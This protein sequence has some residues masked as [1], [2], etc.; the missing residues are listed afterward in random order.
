M[1]SHW[2]SAEGWFLGYNAPLSLALSECY[3]YQGQ[4]VLALRQETQSVDRATTSQSC[5]YNSCSLL[6]VIWLF[7]KPLIWNTIG[8]LRRSSW[9]SGTA[10]NFPSIFFFLWEIMRLTFQLWNDSQCQDCH[11]KNGLAKGWRFGLNWCECFSESSEE[12]P[13]PHINNKFGMVTRMPG[14]WPSALAVQCSWWAISDNG[15]LEKTFIRVWWE[16]AFLEWMVPV[17]FVFLHNIPTHEL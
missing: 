12:H 1:W 3:I 10:G 17:Q 11:V 14:M 15:P 9:G 7:S 6:T 16:K 4:W 2:P 13:K 5:Q 8:P